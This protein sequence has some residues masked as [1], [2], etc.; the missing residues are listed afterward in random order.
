M[1]RCRLLK[2]QTFAYEAPSLGE[3]V[4]G[5]RHLEIPYLD[6]QEQLQVRMKEA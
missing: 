6:D 4:L 5:T 3:S 1:D 2:M